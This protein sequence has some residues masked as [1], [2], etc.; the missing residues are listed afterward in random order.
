[1]VEVTLGPKSAFENNSVTRMPRTVAP[2]RVVN[3]VPASQW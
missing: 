1:V 3:P 2:G